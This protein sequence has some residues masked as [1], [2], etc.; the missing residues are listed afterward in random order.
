M[1]FLNMKRSNTNINKNNTFTSSIEQKRA[2][3]LATSGLASLPL[4]DTP[5][6]Q[7]NQF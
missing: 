2:F 4:K 3:E 5:K 6:N 7:V 1:D